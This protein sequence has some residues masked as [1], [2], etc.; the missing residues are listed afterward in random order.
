MFFWNNRNARRKLSGSLL[1]WFKD[2]LDE[3]GNE[4]ASLLVHTDPRDV[5]GQD[6]VA[7]MERQ[8]LTKGQ[9]LISREKLPIEMMA[10]LYNM[11]DCTINIS[12]AEGFGL[13][14]FESLACGTPILVNMT[15]GL[16][17]QVT[18]GKNW[19]GIGIEPVSKTVIGSQEVP[20]IYEDRI[21]KDDY[22]K[23]LVK[24]YNYTK[25]ERQK[26]GLAGREHVINNYGQE[27]FEKAWVNLMDNVYK[28]RGSWQNRQQYKSWNLVEVA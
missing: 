15:G 24:M 17:E 10:S 16:Q 28:N 23:A 9:A 1:W 20:Y 14:T 13:S 21:S 25:K 5:H 26:M 11:A 8:G 19:F 4:N 7:V 27:N 6:L 12:D 22:I 18:D 3:I 2:F